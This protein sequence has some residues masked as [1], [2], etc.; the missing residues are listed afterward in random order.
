[1]IK[2]EKGKN[3]SMKNYREIHRGVAGACV[4]CKRIR[5]KEPG[6]QGDYI[7][8]NGGKYGY[9]AR[10]GAIAS[11]IIRDAPDVRFPI[12]SC[13]EPEIALTGG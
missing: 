1:M 8:Y 9:C 10:N 5:S 3:K 7:E 6:L 4:S 2:R 13:R 12:N 11:I